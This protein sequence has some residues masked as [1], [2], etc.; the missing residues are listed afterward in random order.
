MSDAKEIEDFYRKL[1]EQWVNGNRAYVVD[2]IMSDSLSKPESAILVVGFTQLLFDT[3]RRKDVEALV[4]L[5]DERIGI[6]HRLPS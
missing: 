2:K 5:L 3:D 1:Y 4:V 6:R